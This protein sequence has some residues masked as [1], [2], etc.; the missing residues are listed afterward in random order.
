[1]WK[2]LAKALS[3]DL[4]NFP[5][6]EEKGIRKGLFTFLRI[7]VASFRGFFRDHCPLHASSLTY[8]TILSLV[9]VI[10]MSLAVSRGFGYG[11][12]LQEQLLARFPEQSTIWNQVFA[13][14]DKLL[15]E[16]T[17][18]F[19]TGVGLLLLFWS[20]LSL[21]TSMESSFNQIWGV[22]KL[23]S[24]RRL[25]ADY[26]SFLL[27]APL[28]FILASSFELYL[29]IKV[30]EHLPLLL[31][32]V[33]LLSLSLFWLLF[34]FIYWFLP[35]TE[36]RVGPALISGIVAGTLYVIVQLAY[37]AF[38]VGVARYGAIYGSFAAVPLFLLWVQVSWY[39]LLFG[40]EL[41][42]SIQCLSEFEYAHRTDELTMGVRLTAALYLLHLITL[43]SQ[44]LAR[45]IFVAR[46]LIP[47]RLLD[48]LLTDLIKASLIYEL[49]DGTYLPK[50]REILLSEAL[51]VLTEGATSDLPFSRAKSFQTLIFHLTSFKEKL[52]AFP[53]N[54]P[55]KNL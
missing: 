10:A 32:F 13:F 28:V 48:E 17:G 47:G 25:F 34:G 43:A 41:S 52:I 30:S 22:Y 46:Y 54:H 20:V 55:L 38:Q 29:E 8:Y 5:L 9:P 36:V 6:Q 26:F 51:L 18:G 2:R 44:P 27:I 15:Q 12:H 7:V 21:L 4:W 50:N 37:I 14:A 11:S 31:S 23:R 40:S 24:W 3:E 42:H 35:N 53:Q 19:F 45:S 16:T 1:M 33:K 39:L 49:S